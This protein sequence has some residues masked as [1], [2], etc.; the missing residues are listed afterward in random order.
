MRPIL[1]RVLLRVC[2]SSSFMHRPR[3]LVVYVFRV[4]YTQP[5]AQRCSFLGPLQKPSL[6][7]WNQATPPQDRDISNNVE[8]QSCSNMSQYLKWLNLDRDEG[9]KAA[10]RNPRRATIRFVALL[11]LINIPV[12]QTR[13]I[14]LILL[15]GPWMRTR[16]T[17]FPEISQPTSQGV[18]H[19][20]AQNTAKSISA[21]TIR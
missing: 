21:N 9:C 20:R 16:S 2:F 5:M 18:V 4:G 14:E 6:Q 7:A 19:P 10:R 13:R 8:H 15:R 17:D 1:A 12:R 3:I 11:F